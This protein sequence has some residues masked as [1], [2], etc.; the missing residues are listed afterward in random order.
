MNLAHITSFFFSLFFSSAY[1]PYS[2]RYP[3]VS[4][5]FSSLHGLSASAVII[6]GF[7]GP[8]EVFV[9]SSCLFT[10][11][12]VRPNNGVIS[13]LS[14]EWAEPSTCGVQ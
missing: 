10:G 4:P 13:L 11:A 5:L 9:H 6:F 3:S 8:E 7:R 2:F 14:C 12:N 1:Y